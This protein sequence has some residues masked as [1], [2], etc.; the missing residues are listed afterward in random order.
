MSTTL[1]TLFSIAR[2]SN[3]NDAFSNFQ[4]LANQLLN[5]SSLFV[6]GNECRIAEIE[7]YLNTSLHPDPFV[8]SRPEQERSCTWYLHKRGKSFRNGTFKGLDL[9][10]GGPKQF[11]GVLIRSIVL[12]DGQLVSGSC[13]VVESILRSASIDSLESLNQSIEGSVFGEI[14]PLRILLDRNDC[15]VIHP[16]RRVGLGLKNSED[17][18]VEA[19]RTAQYRFLTEP[20]DIKKGRKELI[21]SML[22]NG[23]PASEIQCLTNS[24]SKSIERHMQEVI[25]K[26]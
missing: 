4:A 25:E 23:M 20:R 16:S 5:R 9:A 15:R 7:F 1:L 26:S 13:L 3:Q 14:N 11:A 2:N 8:H 24:P 6:F 18:N 12:P 10:F 22:E 21:L 19:F 17:E